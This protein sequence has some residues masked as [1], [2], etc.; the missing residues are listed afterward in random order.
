MLY[1]STRN[2]KDAFTVHQAICSR[3][4]SDGGLFIPYRLPVFS[5]DEICRLSGIGFNSRLAE[6]LNLFFGSHLTGYDI[7]LAVGKRPVRLHQ[8]SQRL[9]LAECWHNTQ[10]QFSELLNALAKLICTDDYEN[11]EVYGWLETGVRIS[12]FFGTVGELLLQDVISIEKPV[13][14]AMVSGNFSGPM[15]AWYAREMGLPIGNIIC[16]CNEN[17]ALWDF[18][19]HG[20]LRTDGV[21]ISSLVPEAD[22]NVPDGL[23]RLISQHT[24][25]EGVQYYADCVHSGRTYYADAAFL[26]NLR[27]GIYVTVSSEPR[28]LSTVSSSFSAH[29][30]VMSVSS[31]LAYAGLQDYR[32]RTGASRM[33][34]IMSDKSPRLDISDIAQILRRPEQEIEKYI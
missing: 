10:W 20:Q 22:I 1:T 25:A 33:A 6:I 18:V 15:A 5:A 11:A 2:K 21:S 28:I 3:R 26:S 12:V 30:C 23:E 16:C 17:A 27:R 8:L 14:I 19:C 13:D 4:A 7:D 29:K 34:L 32:A 9:L 31:A 24:G